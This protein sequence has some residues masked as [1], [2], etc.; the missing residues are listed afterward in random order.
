MEALAWVRFY[1]QGAL[2]KREER[3]YQVSGCRASMVGNVGNLLDT[4]T[5]QAGLLPWLALDPRLVH[6]LR[7]RSKRQQTVRQ[8]PGRQ[9]LHGLAWWTDASD[10]HPAAALVQLSVPGGDS[11]GWE[12]V[13]AS[14]G[15][16][17]D[18]GRCLG[19][20]L[21]WGQ[22][23]EA[24]YHFCAATGYVQPI[25]NSGAGMRLTH[26]ACLPACDADWG[27]RRDG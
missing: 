20:P 27:V 19:Q 3:C 12:L 5:Y 9:R 2:V 18:A 24:S 14:D 10:H 6:R 23:L 25:C 26:P 11:L 21:F 15:G 16:T 1:D 17:A 22:A 7:D 8:Q 4:C 13:R